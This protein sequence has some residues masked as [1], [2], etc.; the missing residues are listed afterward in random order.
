MNETKN[1]KTFEVESYI[2]GGD[3]TD[4]DSLTDV[5]MEVQTSCVWSVLHGHCRAVHVPLEPVMARD[6]S[7][8]NTM[9]KVGV[10]SM[11]GTS[12]RLRETPL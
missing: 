8:I 9:I 5:S 7:Q 6:E 3:L 10:N 1:L 11:S 2:D 12:R 4:Y